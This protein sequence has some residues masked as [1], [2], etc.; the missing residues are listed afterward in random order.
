MPELK[1]RLHDRP[2]HR[3][4]G[5]RRAD[6]GDAAHG[7]DRDHHRRGR[8]QGRARADR[9]RGAARCSA[10]RR[11]S[12]GR[13]PRRSTPPARPE[14][15]ERE[16]AEG[17]VLDRYLPAQLTDD[18]LA[19]LVAAAV[20][21]AGASGP[22]DMGAVMKI[23]QPRVAGRADGKRVSDEVRRRRPADGRRRPRP[24]PSPRPL[25]SGPRPVAEFH[26]RRLPPRWPR[27]R[28]VAAR[29]GLV[30]RGAGDGC[31]LP[32]APR[33]E[34]GFGFGLGGGGGE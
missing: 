8:R 30:A 34:V 10:A 3:D 4:E 2:Q 11:R 12:A 5:A 29:R 21:E 20:A 15:A 33:P 6:H 18:E 13:P 17:E 7:A 32:P 23:V 22:R 24:R 9:R 14:L 31:P 27:G 28:L 16:R 25:A 19:E 1:E 26:R